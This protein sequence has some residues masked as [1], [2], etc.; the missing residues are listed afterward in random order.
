MSDR[1]V[2]ACRF[3]VRGVVQGVAFRWSARRAAERL[4]VA[5]WVRNRPDGTVVAWAEADSVRLEAFEAWLCEGPPAARVAGV[6]PE[7]AE[8]VGLEGF[9]VRF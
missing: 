1:P 6:D 9:E 5:G 7:P 8:P 3:V 4:G 2:L